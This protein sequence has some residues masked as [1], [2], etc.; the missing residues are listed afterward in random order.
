MTPGPTPVPEETLLELIQTLR[1]L[2]QFHPRV[3]ELH[4]PVDRFKAGIDRA[5]LTAHAYVQALQGARERFETGISVG[6]NQFRRTGRGRRSCVRNK[7][8]NGEV[9]L[10]A[11]P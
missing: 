11:D 7:I 1:L 8:G 4:P 6:D 3:S 5:Q 9:D 2:R 10:V